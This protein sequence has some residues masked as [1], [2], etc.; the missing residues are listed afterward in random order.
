MLGIGC[1][2]VCPLQWHG[3]DKLMTI[4][5]LPPTSPSPCSGGRK[6]QLFNAAA[7][8]GCILA[9]P[10]L[11]YTIPR[12]NIFFP[13]FSHTSRGN[14]TGGLQRIASLPGQIIILIKIGVGGI[15]I[16]SRISS[17]G[18]SFGDGQEYLFFNNIFANQLIVSMGSG[19]FRR[20]VPSRM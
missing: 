17:P 15:S 13:S 2:Q 18:F 16:Y 1:A 8:G 3:Y 9:G 19:N 12:R 6:A 11:A 5:I 10:V 20:T 4:D 7:T 14:E